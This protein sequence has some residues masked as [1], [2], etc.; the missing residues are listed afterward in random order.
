M[1]V[2]MRILSFYQP[3]PQSFLYLIRKCFWGRSHQP[4]KSNYYLAPVPPRPTPC[5]VFFEA[6]QRTKSFNTF[7]HDQSSKDHQLVSMAVSEF[8]SL[9]FSRARM[10]TVE[11]VQG[12]G[13]D[14]KCI[15]LR[16]TQASTLI[17]S[18]LLLSSS[19]PF[20]LL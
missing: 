1:N 2:G 13:K 10:S 7:Y 15:A 14:F 6:H 4:G 17:A 5:G 16:L 18:S 9:C 12:I 8:I 3:L 19:K 20:S 11:A